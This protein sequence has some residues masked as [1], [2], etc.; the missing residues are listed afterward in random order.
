MD[1]RIKPGHDEKEAATLPKS[2]GRK[3]MM[4]SHPSNRTTVL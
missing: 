4:A 2:R 3:W 1:A